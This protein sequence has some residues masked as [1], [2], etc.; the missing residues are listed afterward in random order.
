MIQNKNELGYFEVYDILL[1]TGVESFTLVVEIRT[2]F[3]TAGGGI[4]N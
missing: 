3:A 1:S 2:E 4:R